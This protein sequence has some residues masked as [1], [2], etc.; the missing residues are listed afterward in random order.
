MRPVGS[1]EQDH[2][3]RPTTWRRHLFP[4]AGV[5]VT[6]LAVIGALVV[7]GLAEWANST[8]HGGPAEVD[9]NRQ[10]LRHFL[11]VIWAAASIVP[12]LVAAIARRLDRR[13]WPWAAVATACL[14]VAGYRGLTAQPGTWCLF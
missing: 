12:L 6:T 4:V 7:S 5:L 9:V 14:A 1:C 3:R 11:V 2:D 10:E 13:S 8:C